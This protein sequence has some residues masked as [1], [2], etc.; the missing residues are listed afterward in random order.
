[1]KAWLIGGIIGII[2]AVVNSFF[3]GGAIGEFFSLIFRLIGYPWGVCSGEDCWGLA[4]IIGDVL[5]I[6]S[7]FIIGWIVGKI[8]ERK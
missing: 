5:L 3:L 1:M 6:I 8:K 2:L 4:I 7:G